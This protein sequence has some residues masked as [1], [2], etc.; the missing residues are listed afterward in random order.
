M[1]F[2]KVLL[3]CFLFLAPM[4]FARRCAGT[5]SNSMLRRSTTS[6][7]WQLGYHGSSAFACPAAAR[8]ATP[9]SPWVSGPPA[10]SLKRRWKFWRT[11]EWR[12]LHRLY[13]S[14]TYSSLEMTRV[15][16]VALRKS[17]RPDAVPPQ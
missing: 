12:V 6:S 1:M 3:M 8:P 7:S 4:T 9:A 10:P 16:S 5:L 15:P 17:S 14:I 2:Y 13:T 11:W